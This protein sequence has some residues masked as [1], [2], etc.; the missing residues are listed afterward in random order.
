MDKTIFQHL[1]V[2]L[3]HAIFI[4]FL[5][6]FFTRLQLYV[7]TLRGKEV[8]SLPSHVFLHVCDLFSYANVNVNMYF[9]AVLLL[10]GS[11]SH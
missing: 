4:F 1:E 10:V 8:H 6:L 9:E 7:V 2:Y 11:L 3:N 5:L